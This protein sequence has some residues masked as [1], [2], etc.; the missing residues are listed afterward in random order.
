MAAVLNNAF[1]LAV[2][3]LLNQLPTLDDLLRTLN[4]EEGLRDGSRYL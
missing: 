2:A 3:R 4:R 1:L